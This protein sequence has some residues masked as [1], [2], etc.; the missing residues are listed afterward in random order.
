[1]TAPMRVRVGVRALAGVTAVVALL[2]VVLAG[3]AEAHF[4]GFD[5]VDGCEI[6]WEDETT[7]DAERQAAQSAWEALKGGDD[8]VDLAPDAWNTNA[9][10][11]WKDANRSDVTWVGLYESETS[12]D[13]IHLNTFYL[14]S[15]GSC[16]RRNVA[17][18]ELGHAHGLDHS[19]NSNTGNVMN[20]Y[21]INVCS[22]KPHDI[23]DYVELWGSSYVPPPTPTTFCLACVEP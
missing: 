21:A 4:L 16:M 2:G 17:I 19:S 1:M 14:Q 18:H 13:D 12:A 3:T 9:D 7:W 23:A 5:S 6:R 22:L 10:L 20:Q 11:E 8:C 15:Y